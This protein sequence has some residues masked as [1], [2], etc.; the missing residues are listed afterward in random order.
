MKPIWP[1]WPELS[2]QVIDFKPVSIGF[3]AYY[4]ITPPLCTVQYCTV[5]IPDCVRLGRQKRDKSGGNRIFHPYSS[6]FPTLLQASPFPMLQKLLFFQTELTKKILFGDWNMMF[7]YRFFLFRPNGLAIYSTV[8]AHLLSFKY[9]TFW[10]LVFYCMSHCCVK[11]SPL[12]WI[13]PTLSLSLCLSLSITWYLKQE[14]SLLLAQKSEIIMY[15]IDLKI[16]KSNTIS[17][18]PKNALNHIYF[19]KMCEI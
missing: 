7:I 9:L 16:C 4:S 12:S 8:K 13:F 19:K 18:I 2:N 6:S 17:H 1:R 3:C 5:G 11:K 15:S 14:G 10:W